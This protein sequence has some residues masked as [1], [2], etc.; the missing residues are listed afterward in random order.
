MTA[1]LTMNQII[2]AAV[3]RDVARTEAALRALADGDGERAAAISRGWSHLVAMLREHH[4][5]ED[6][7]V[8]PYLRS[9]G[10]D[11]SLLAAMESEHQALADALTRGTEAVASVVAEPT[12]AQAVA[13]AEVVAHSGQ[14]IGDHLDHEER[15]I[16]P[17]IRGRAGSPGWKAVERKF[18]AGGAT[19][20]GNMM[21]WLQDGA[22][23][24]VRTALRQTIPPPVL[25]VL[26]AAFGRGYRK[27]V[28][29][30][31]ADA[32]VR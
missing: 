22:T 18:R 13:A 14:V 25:F 31:W 8:W 20:A 16:E 30:V 32:P 2:H 10:V 5:Q 29:P 28:A 3:R 4:Q 15:D 12:R 24:Q 9:E 21:A 7:L 6:A 1:E 17:L 26:V 11:G 23:P 19:R 27:N